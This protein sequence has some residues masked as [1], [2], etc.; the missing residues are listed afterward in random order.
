M[1]K[2][3]KKQLSLYWS[4][5]EVKGHSITNKA[6]YRFVNYHQNNEILSKSHH[7]IYGYI[8]TLPISF[9]PALIVSRPIANVVLSDITGLV[10]YKAHLLMSALWS[11]GS[12]L[13]TSDHTTFSQM[14]N[15]ISENKNQSEALSFRVKSPQIICYCFSLNDNA[16]WEISVYI[17]SL[18]GYN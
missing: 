16:S 13:S 10:N 17:S 18:D 6:P 3:K 15:V 9:C 2:K 1:K 5:Y 12:T 11:A 4:S 8:F 7:S 14:D